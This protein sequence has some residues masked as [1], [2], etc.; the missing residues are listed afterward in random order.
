MVMRSGQGLG[1]LSRVSARS[2]PADAGGHGVPEPGQVPDVRLPGRVD[3]FLE[4]RP[5]E[6]NRPQGA[7]EHTAD[8]R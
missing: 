7:G 1:T 6:Y 4:R 8:G 3:A 5:P 2:E